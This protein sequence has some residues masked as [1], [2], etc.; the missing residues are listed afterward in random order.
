MDSIR[1]KLVTWYKSGGERLGEF[2]TNRLATRFSKPSGVTAGSSLVTKAAIFTVFTCI[3]P[4]VIVGWYLTSQTVDSLTQAAIE[5]NN[6]VAERIASDLEN[7]ILTKKNFLLA[8]SG[9]EQVRAMDPVK[10]REYLLQIQQYNVGNEPLFIAD[11][12]GRQICRTDN[13]ALV[14]IADRAYFKAAMQGAINFSNP[15]YSKVTNQ[16]TIL[17]AAPIYG[18]DNKVV[19]VLGANI[20]VY[21]LQN[22]IDQ[23]LAQNPGYIVAVIDGDRVPLYHPFE[24]A[25]VAERRSLDEKFYSDAAAAKTGNTDAIV[26]SQEYF[27]S[28]RPVNGTEWVVL[29]FY[30]KETALQT[31]YDTA[32]HGI[33]F[34][35]LFVCVFA[36]AGFFVTRRALLPLKELMASV[37]AVAGGNLLHRI[38][39]SNRRDEL[40]HL[41]MAFGNM[42]E[43][44]RQ[45]VQQVKGA[46][47][48]VGE[49]SRHVAKAAAQSSQASQQVAQSIQDMAAQIA[50]QEQASATTEQ[51]LGQLVQL[52]ASVSERAR[53]VVQASHECSA[54]AVQ[55]QAVV[56]ET[57]ARMQSIKALVVSSAQK[58]AALGQSAQEVNQIT[59]MITAITKQTNLLALNA[60]IEAARAGEAGRGFAVVAD[61]VRKLAE[62]S[63]QAVNNITLI[64]D[65]VRVETGQAVAAMQESAARV[66]QGADIAATL[67]VAFTNIMAAIANMEKQADAITG[68]M[69]REAALCREALAAV[70]NI[71][72]LTTET[73]RGVQEIAAVSEEQAAAAQDIANTIVVMEK[74]S[75]EL[76]IIVGQFKA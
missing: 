3:V 14:N 28:Y 72:R 15:I 8:T 71:N 1:Q 7:Y 36:A 18:A 16:L 51:L 40:G 61:E 69:A 59:D 4:L 41:T 60:A 6:K 46:A 57:I 74:L 48:Q 47:S 32:A 37:E 65:K 76:A 66:E 10:T 27:I 34:T 39:A 19:G 30:P 42:T 12:D 33:R 58:V 21:N 73:S 11:A 56:D 35:M 68:E 9:K 62:Q 17:G 23:I 5:R 54:V 55:G 45:I 70:A 44:L 13:A 22:K 53:H 31:A 52:S 38:S 64:I 25:A 63:A 29:S 20:S 50:H 67:G 2:V 43:N 26:R 49:T 75:A 24:A